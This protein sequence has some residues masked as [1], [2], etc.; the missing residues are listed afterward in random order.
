H[1]GRLRA[2]RRHGDP[3]TRDAALGQPAPARPGAE[4]FRPGRHHC[5][6]PRRLRGKGGED[7]R[8][9]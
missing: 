5:W 8:R 1:H 6:L 9:D 4:G 3:T 7:G 2:C